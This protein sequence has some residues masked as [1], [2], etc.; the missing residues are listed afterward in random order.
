M[1]HNY[2]VNS[3][4]SI[5]IEKLRETVKIDHNK[6]AR[7]RHRL[8]NLVL[9]R[10]FFLVIPVTFCM[11]RVIETCSFEKKI[12]KNRQNVFSDFND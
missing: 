4:T 2:T 3:A 12:I 6:K 5:L 7:K 10:S 11:R 8:C 1:A 9:E